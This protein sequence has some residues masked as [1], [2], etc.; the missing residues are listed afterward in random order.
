[1]PHTSS[2]QPVAGRRWLPTT[3]R[4]RLTTLA[5]VAATLTGGTV[6]GVVIA[7]DAGDKGPLVG[8]TDMSGLPT[9]TASDWVTNGDHAVVIEMVPGSEHRGALPDGETSGREGHIPRIATM[10]VDQV[11]WSRPGAAAAP[12]TYRTELPGWWRDGSG[13]REF[14]WKDEPRYEEGHRYIA[15][16]I[17][18][19]DGKWGATLHAM[20][21]DDGKVGTGENEGTVVSSRSTDALEGLEKAANGK[22]ATAVK[23]LL[24]AAAP[25]N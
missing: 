16:L 7:D 21:Y 5:V 1:M 15:L 22:S 8:R 25:Q 23:Q 19:D 14:A 13:E 4:S 17:K 20:P 2:D 10:R 3:R 11:L 6:V 12:K 18:G 24:N 9:L